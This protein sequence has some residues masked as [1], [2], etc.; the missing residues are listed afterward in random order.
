[1]LS[2]IIT[3]YTKDKSKKKTTE[4]V[5]RQINNQEVEPSIL[6]LEN[7][8]Y[9]KPQKSINI[10]LTYFEFIDYL[11]T[12]FS[13]F[14]NRS[15]VKD[16]KEDVLDYNSLKLISLKK[17][18][19][20]Y[21]LKPK[22]FK[23][24]IFIVNAL[25]QQNKSDSNIDKFDIY[26]GP[27]QIEICLLSNKKVLDG[28]G[29]EIKLESFLKPYSQQFLDR[30]DNQYEI[31][32]KSFPINN[33]SKLDCLN[34]VMENDCCDIGKFIKFSFKGSDEFGW[35]C[36]KDLMDHNFDFRNFIYEDEE[37][38]VIGRL[39]ALTEIYNSDMSLYFN[40]SDRQSQ[41]ILEE[42][43]NN[44]YDISKVNPNEVSKD[45][46]YFIPLCIQMGV[47]FF[48]IYKRFK[49]LTLEVACL[50][51]C[52]FDFDEIDDLDVPFIDVL[53]GC[54]LEMFGKEISLDLLVQ[55]FCNENVKNYEVHVD[56]RTNDRF[57]RK[58][59]D[60]C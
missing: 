7:D 34:W 20:D 37:S 57:L 58:L 59:K 53:K 12:Y 24:P 25:L 4:F 18:Y 33:Q 48:R 30:W 51:K 22:N 31:L 35:V 39:T 9:F 41:L 15:L 55:S 36:C 49:E 1:M 11:F 60:I 45:H 16:F 27:S 17:I 2:S 32:L 28:D 13:D 3:K 52:G 46:L 21:L 44:G 54:C 6:T 43:L 14:I 19:D 26:E 47:P 40:F 56:A 29:E 10:H 23:T 50:F 42:L 8:F 38:F 5:F